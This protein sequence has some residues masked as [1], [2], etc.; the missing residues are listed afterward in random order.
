M[1][2]RKIDL[3]ELSETERNKVLGEAKTYLETQKREAKII[4]KRSGSLKFRLK[5]FWYSKGQAY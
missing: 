3:L 2:T 1:E 5:F 4:K